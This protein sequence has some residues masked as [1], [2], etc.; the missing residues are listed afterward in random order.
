MMPRLLGFLLVVAS[1]GLI[2][3]VRYQVWELTTAGLQAGRLAHAET[4]LTGQVRG[5]LDGDGVPE[6]LSIEDGLLTIRTDSEARWSSPVDWEVQQ[7]VIADLNRDTRPEAVLLVSRPFQPWPV[8]AWLP[9]GGR[10]DDFH[11]AQGY[12]SHIILIGWEGDAFGE[13]W[14]GPAMAAPVRQFAVASPDGG[15]QILLTLEGEYDDSASRPARRF[16]LWKWNGFGFRLVSDLEG[17]FHEMQVI[18][19]G[20]RLFLV[21]RF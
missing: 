5:D 20:N 6:D 7:A 19:E 15:G 11:D 4:A 18:Q 13:L 10:I 14:A 16:K 1:L 21:L 12:S 3:P 8:D 17:A 9:Y 2:S